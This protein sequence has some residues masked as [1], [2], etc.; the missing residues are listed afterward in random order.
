MIEE[1]INN[2]SNPNSESQLFAKKTIKNVNDLYKFSG[3]DIEKY[4]GL[5][6]LSDDARIF[7]YYCSS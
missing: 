5:A 2:L 1:I 4:N 3:F 7:V 6:N